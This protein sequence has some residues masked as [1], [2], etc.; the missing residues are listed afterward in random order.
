MNPDI[1]RWDD[2]YRDA[3]AADF[4]AVDE[5][6][7]NHDRLLAGEGRALDVACGAGANAIFVASRGYTTIGVDG[8]V[9]GLRLA[10]RR[11]KEIGVTLHLINADLERYRPPPA[12]FD[13][14]LVFR[15]LNRS[16]FDALEQTLHPRGVL[17]Y[18]TFNRNLLDVK[19]EFNPEYLLKPGELPGFFGALEQVATNDRAGNSDVFSWWIGRKPMS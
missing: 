1:L 3:G 5:L 4:V 8:S 12:A 11:A 17:F 7:K 9:R 13:L 15:Y 16:L 14:V 2:K 10:A 18:K 6:L 19:P